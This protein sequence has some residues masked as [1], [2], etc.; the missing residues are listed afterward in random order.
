MW[1][2][3]FAIT[4]HNS[5]ALLRHLEEQLR[6]IVWQADAAMASGITRERAGVHGNAAPGEPLH[7]WH[8][9]IVIRFRT[10]RL[11]FLEDAEHTARRGMT[12]RARAHGRAADQN[13]V[14]IDV[15]RLLRN[16]DKE[17]ERTLGR[18][19]RMPP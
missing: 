18:N 2:G 5:A 12:F 3:R 13:P 11:L 16:A 8:W 9:R 15:H 7:V 6:E 4:D 10:M 14:A 19:F 17:H 1:C